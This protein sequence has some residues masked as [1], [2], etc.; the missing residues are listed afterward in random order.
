MHH[1][2]V[3]AEREVSGLVVARVG[4]AEATSAAALPWVVLDGAGRA[5]TPPGEFLR[6]LPACGN[7]LASCRSYAF[8]LLR[9]FR[10]LDR[11]ERRM[12]PCEARGCTRLRPL[13]AD[14]PQPGA[15]PAPPGRARSAVI[16]RAHRQA[17]PAVGL[18]PGDHQ[19][20]GVGAG[21]VL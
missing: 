18:C 17:V 8:D 20:R 19:P 12:E 21:G 5:I 2:V 14:V 13:A 1:D 4:R 9:W 16:E 15:G 6:E 3:I 7:T 10:F 11:D